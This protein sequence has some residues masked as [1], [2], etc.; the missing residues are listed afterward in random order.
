[1]TFNPSAFLPSFLAASDT[2]KTDFF[3]GKIPLWCWG[4]LLALIASMLAIDL[5]RH[6]D[7]HEPTASEAFKES[8]VWVG[9]SLAFGG[10]VAWQ[11]GSKAFGEYLSGYVIEKSLSVDNVFVWALIFS[12]FKIPLRYQH[13]VLFWGIFG[14]L[15][16][17]AIFIVLGSALITKFWWMLLLFGAFLVFTGVKILLHKEDDETESKTVGL[18]LL[19]K[20]M[21]VTDKYDGHKFFTMENAKR[22]A[23]PLFACLVVVEITDIIFAV[24]SVPAILAVARSPF[25]VFA[26]N[27]FAIL[28]L[29]AMYFLLADA[30]ER[31]K[32]LSVSLG[33]ILVFVG[34]KMIASHWY[35]LDTRI[36]L[37][38]IIVVLSGG[39]I[40]S[41]KSAPKNDAPKLH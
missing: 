28:G 40:A 29:R 35:H 13:R 16:F 25:I 38:V 20:I 21:P 4:L 12:A 14:A 39:I 9:V 17:R 33:I 32:Y 27:A 10:F 1:V 31:F 41:L 7:E 11:F 34:F 19:R 22:A 2:D 23:T 24:D 18:N 8:L 36:S 30:K 15:A 6:D 5:I 3:D 26:S 37:A